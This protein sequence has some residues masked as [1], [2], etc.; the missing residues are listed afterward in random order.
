MKLLEAA[1]IIGFAEGVPLENQIAGK[2]L[3]SNDIRNQH[4]CAAVDVFLALSTHHG[5]GKTHCCAP[6]VQAHQ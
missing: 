6:A 1:G 3:V 2:V 4:R 5:A